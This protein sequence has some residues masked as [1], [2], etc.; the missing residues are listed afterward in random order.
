MANSKNTNNRRR[1][2]SRDEALILLTQKEASLAKGLEDL[3]KDGELSS[4]AI[5]KLKK[6]HGVI[7]NLCGDEKAR[8]SLL[9]L[10]IGHAIEK[11]DKGGPV[12]YDIALFYINW[13]IKHPGDIHNAKND[14]LL[15]RIMND[16][17][18]LA[19]EADNWAKALGNN[20]NDDDEN[21]VEISLK[22]MTKKFYPSIEKFGATHKTF[23]SA[24]L[25]NVAAAEYYWPHI[26]SHKPKTLVEKV[27][28]AAEDWDK[29]EEECFETA[30]SRI[31]RYME[32]Y[33]RY[34]LLFN[35]SDP[36]FYRNRGYDSNSFT[37]PFE[38]DGRFSKQDIERLETIRQYCHKGVHAAR[39]SQKI[40]M[41]GDAALASYTAGPARKAKLL[42]D[43]AFVQKMLVGAVPI[44]GRD[45]YQNALKSLLNEIKTYLESHDEID[46]KRTRDDLAVGI[47]N[48][49]LFEDGDFG[50][51]LDNCPFFTKE[52]LLKINK[53]DSKDSKAYINNIRS[54]IVIATKAY[55]T[56]RTREERTKF[57]STLLALKNR[58]K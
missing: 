47:A 14:K 51:A 21:Y 25:K 4:S 17:I 2:K 36:I 41:G 12:T 32:A 16:L 29:N 50:T 35:I 26:R 5:R 43:T 45:Q 3:A 39:E 31:R 42:D 34:T 57:L 53:D 15:R 10:R 44:V 9:I 23:L 1:I 20:K 18:T 55:V 6:M 33:C 7:L 24:L 46:I 11:A 52:Q 56:K 28:E 37:L 27:K 38:L 22:S 40:F 19:E 58:V 13:I 49:I 48:I 54:V 30:T 8:D